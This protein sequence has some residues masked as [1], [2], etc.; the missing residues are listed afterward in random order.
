MESQE[1]EAEDE[2]AILYGLRPVNLH[3]L[4]GE[5]PLNACPLVPGPPPWFFK[6]I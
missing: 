4:Q 6:I 5:A 3:E 2:K 1:M